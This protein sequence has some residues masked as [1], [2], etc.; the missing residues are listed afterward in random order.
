M[1]IPADTYH[2]SYKCV[3]SLQ[4][5]QFIDDTITE[6]LMA[7]DTYKG[8][9]K[10]GKIAEIWHLLNSHLIPAAIAVVEGFRDAETEFNNDYVLIMLVL[11]GAEC[12]LLIL[13]AAM[14]RF[15]IVTVDGCYDILI[16]LVRR[17][18]PFHILASEPLSEYL[19]NRQK[20]DESVGLSPEERIIRNSSNCIICMGANG[21]IELIN[22]SVTKILGYTPEQVLGQPLSTLL[23]L[24][25]GTIIDQRM[26][27]M[28]ARQAGPLYEDHTICVSD[29]GTE[30]HCSISLLALFSRDVVSSYVAIL[31][32]ETSF[33]AQQTE[34]ETAKAQSEML[35]YQILPRGI[36][37]RLNAGEKDIS[38][39]IPSAT[40]MFIDIV[41]FSEYAESLTPQEIMGNLAL[42]FSGF[43]GKIAGY[44]R[45]IKIKLIGDVYMAAGGLFDPERPPNT[46]AEQMVRFGLEALDIIEEV[47]VKLGAALAVRIGI[48]SGGPVFAGVLGTDK[49][50]FDIIGDPINVAAR[51]QSTD[52]P[53][54]I[55]ISESTHALLNLGD[56]TVAPRGLVFLKGKG[57][58]QT[59]LIEP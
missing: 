6:I 28:A 1:N 5:T 29:S 46:H 10:T 38:F 25:Q 59:Y 14:M 11:F 4:L 41:K 31:K 15:Y 7:A 16:A 54:F 39:S 51:L 45:L 9:L 37:T 18:S 36:V 21:G 33:M 30:I 58:L 19:L 56:F 57:Q 27:L 34:A 23:E 20:A 43:D 55:H 2:R 49:P 42:V 12:V 22:P 3:S 52:L 40:V 50:V 13:Q 17:V 35:L 47:N 32:D 26:R 8:N 44:D 53:G 24:E 48:N